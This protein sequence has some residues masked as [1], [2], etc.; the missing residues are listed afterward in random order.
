MFLVK[1]GYMITEKKKELL[2]I[3]KNGLNSYKLRRWEDA[4]K[5]FSDALKIDPQDGPSKL[6]LERSQN[7]K[8]NPPP[9]DWDGVFIMTTK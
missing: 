4:I 5:Y 1:G 2:K 8:T 6:Y 7:Y 3:Y 9:D